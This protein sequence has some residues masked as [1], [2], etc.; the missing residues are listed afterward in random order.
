MA[1]ADM[2][3]SLRGIMGD[4][5]FLHH[6]LRMLKLPETT[7]EIHCGPALTQYEAGTRTIT[8]LAHNYIEQQLQKDDYISPTA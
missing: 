5:S 4:E 6:V 7:V 8:L 1:G 2:V 3:H